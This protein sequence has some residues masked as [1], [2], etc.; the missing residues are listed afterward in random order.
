M[1]CAVAR[2][3][4]LGLRRCRTGVSRRSNNYSLTLRHGR[5]ALLPKALFNNRKKGAEQQTDR[6]DTVAPV[7]G[8]D[9][10]D[11]TDAPE[12]LDLLEEIW[13]EVRTKETS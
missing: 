8:E 9:S 1:L 13:Y 11:W 10:P 5:Q 6:E 3:L 2:P 4:Q 7:W 12:Q